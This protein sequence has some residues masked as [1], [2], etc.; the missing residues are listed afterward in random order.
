MDYLERANLILEVWGNQIPVQLKEGDMRSTKQ[1]MSANVNLS[2]A[3]VA[4]VSQRHNPI[5]SPLHSHIRS[6]MRSR[7]HCHLCD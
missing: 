1:H 6:L 5:R 3:N 7:V 2:A 4:L